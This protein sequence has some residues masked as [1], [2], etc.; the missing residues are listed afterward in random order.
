ML[1]WPRPFMLT[2]AAPFGTMVPAA[3]SMREQGHAHHVARK[4]GE[5]W[6]AH[7]QDVGLVLNV[8]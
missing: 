5:F 8:L 3:T 6:G 4:A 2:A 1:P 7:K